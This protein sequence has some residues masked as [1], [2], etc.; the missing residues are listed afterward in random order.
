MK[1]VLTTQVSQADLPQGH[2]LVYSRGAAFAEIRPPPSLPALLKGAL[3]GA[4]PNACG[5][6]SPERKGFWCPFPPKPKP[7]S[8]RRWLA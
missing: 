8:S 3:V 4:S 2:C 6:C 1:S 7:H 5:K